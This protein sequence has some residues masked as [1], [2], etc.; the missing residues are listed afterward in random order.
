MTATTQLQVSLGERSYPILLGDGLVHQGT[1]EFAELIDG[2]QVALISN[3]TVFDL[4]GKAMAAQIA[5]H[6]SDHIKLLIPDGESHKNW[7]TLNTVFDALLKARFDRNCVLVVFGGGVVGDLGGLAAGLYQRGVDFVQVPTTLLAQ[8]DSSVG[9]K[10]AV[11][12]PAG[13]NMIGVFHQPR[14]VLADMSVLTTLPQRELSA[15]LAEMLKHG[16]IADVDYLE[17][18]ENNMATLRQCDSALMADAVKRSC[19]IKAA[20]VAADEREA[21][22]RATLNFGHTFGHAIESGMG[23]GKWL[24]GE[25]VAAGMVMAADLSHRSG[26]L[27]TGDIDRIK[28]ANLSAELPVA[29]PTWPADRYIE[30]M[31]V[32][33]KAS[34]GIPRF[35]LLNG[36]G[37]AELKNVDER[38]VRE[39]LSAHATL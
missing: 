8:V 28:S 34:Q 7:S 13:K 6:A 38:L 37:R 36:L 17:S 2:R 35:V 30:L 25:A 11:N 4:H 14:L 27:D 5:Q 10:T 23:Y 9:G 16:A 22:L 1:D 21:G 20:V 31:A 32:D 3:Q 19:E 18:L 12:H 29:G 26:Q 33:K 15:G 24:H 39:T